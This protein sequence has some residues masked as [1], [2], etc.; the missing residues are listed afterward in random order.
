MA[1]HLDTKR[2]PVKI[3]LLFNFLWRMDVEANKKDFMKIHVW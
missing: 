1:A 2:Y 3:G